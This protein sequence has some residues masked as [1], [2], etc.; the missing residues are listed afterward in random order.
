MNT[1]LIPKVLMFNVKFFTYLESETNLAST[2]KRKSNNTV[3]KMHS[4]EYQ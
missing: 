1:P 4:K 3:K 2:M